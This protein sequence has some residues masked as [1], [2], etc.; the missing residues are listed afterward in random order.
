MVFGL[1]IPWIQNQFVFKFF[2]GLIEFPGFHINQA[3][4][5]M[6]HW[7][8]TIE[9]RCRP[10]FFQRLLSLTLFVISLAEQDM[11]LGSITSVRDHLLD[12]LLSILLFPFLDQRKR[13]SVVDADIERLGDY[14][15]RQQLRCPSV[16]LQDE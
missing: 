4:I 5:I 8:L 12:H 11:K 10:Q 1:D 13:Q 15:V 9:R 2:R 14:Y 6:D 7:S 3:G 16:I